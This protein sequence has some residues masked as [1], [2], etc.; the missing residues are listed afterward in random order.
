MSFFLKDF[1]SSL[2]DLLNDIAQLLENFRPG[3]KAKN[4]GIVCKVRISTPAIS[5]FLMSSISNNYRVDLDTATWWGN[6]Q[7]LQLS[8]E[9]GTKSYSK[10]SYYSSIVLPLKAAAPHY[11]ILLFIRFWQGLGH[12]MSKL[13]PGQSV[14][15]MME[16][17]VAGN[18][19]GEN[20]I[21]RQLVYIRPFFGGGG[22]L[23][24]V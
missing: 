8:W 5:D 3:A 11:S 1:S 6:V 14:I 23:H 7:L 2:T 24:G 19:Q 18:R 20:V 9:T 4:L 10:L 12:H 13:H 16:S 21:I 22:G 17:N 15:H